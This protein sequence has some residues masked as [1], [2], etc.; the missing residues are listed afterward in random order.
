MDLR[1]FVLTAHTPHMQFNRIL[2][3]ATIVFHAVSGKV[4][5]PCISHP[6]QVRLPRIGSRLPVFRN[7]IT[8]SSWRAYI[9]SGFL[10]HIMA[11]RIQH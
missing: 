6:M 11:R 1:E 7:N 8:A 2:F 5:R 3:L 9:I 4:S 10:E